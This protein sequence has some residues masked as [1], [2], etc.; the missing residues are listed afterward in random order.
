VPAVSPE[1]SAVV[2]ISRRSLLAL[3]ASVVAFASC[4]P[5][6]HAV[7]DARA[8][9]VDPA[10]IDAK[11]LLPP[12]PAE[13][14]PR[15]LREIDELLALQAA[16]TPEEAAQARAD[17]EPSVFRFADALGL[18]D[19]MGAQELPALARLFAQ[20]KDD[21]IAVMNRAKSSFERRRPFLVETRIEPI[22]RKPVSTSY[23]SGHATLGY[24]T[25]TLL[26]AMVPE[27]RDA[28]M[29]RADRY[30]RHRMVA[31]VHFRSDVEAGRTMGL[32]I[33]ARMLESRAYRAEAGPAERELRAALGLGAK[34]ARRRGVA[35]ASDVPPPAMPASTTVPRGSHSF[36][37]VFVP[38]ADS[39]VPAFDVPPAA[40]RA[41]SSRSRRMRV[42]ALTAWR[43]AAEF[44]TL[45]AS[46]IG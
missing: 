39:A 6:R 33:A 41:A 4:T 27:R 32:A 46:S 18:P 8:H 20:V 22:V 5:V 13:G 42:H 38:P 17:A 7:L 3:L 24:M 26:A 2:A 34:P 36:D 44:D 45:V 15:A 29:R 14:S 28:L 43:A 1:G 16:R 23:P 37:A 11:A 35:D 25:A 19:G 12:P 31:G 21:E 40:V 9:F 10:A 30:A